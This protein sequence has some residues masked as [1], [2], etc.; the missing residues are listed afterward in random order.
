MR[1]SSLPPAPLVRGP[2]DRGPRRSAGEGR[3][4]TPRR[5]GRAI[6]LATGPSAVGAAPRQARE[7][8]YD[9]TRELML[10]ARERPAARPGA[11]VR[12]DGHP[13]G[14]RR[15]RGGRAAVLRGPAARRRLHP[16]TGDRR[17]Q[18]SV[19][20]SG[21]WRIVFRFED[22]EAVDVTLIDYH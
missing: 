14:A 7:L 11:R 4:L 8:T 9:Q 19:R 17:G 18:W 21:N 12:D 20:V 3:R 13:A 15:R 22:G 1:A 6:E 10:V 2:G 5:A 16:L